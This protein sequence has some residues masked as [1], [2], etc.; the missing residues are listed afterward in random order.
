M[1]KKKNFLHR[2]F[3]KTLSVSRGEKAINARISAALKDWQNRHG[4]CRHCRVDDVAEE[5]GFSREQ[6]TFY[7]HT[8]MKRGFVN[9]RSELRML[10]AETLLLENPD[11]PAYAVGEVVGIPDKSNFRKEFRKFTGLSP[12]AWR[13]SR[14][15]KLRH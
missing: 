4:Y 13:A 1:Y 8:V 6:L 12:S 7:F 14:L 11:T 15:E 2:L 5:L 3:G 10:Y 9:W